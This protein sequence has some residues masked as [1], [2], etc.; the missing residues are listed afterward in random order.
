MLKCKLVK[1]GVR[2]KDELMRVSS[3]QLGSGYTG[4]YLEFQMI[5][6]I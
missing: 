3:K 4:L 2:K 6:I 1:L 5:V